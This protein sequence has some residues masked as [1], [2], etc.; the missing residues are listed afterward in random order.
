MKG[1]TFG[2][3]TKQ[4]LRFEWK[5]DNGDPRW[6]ERQFLWNITQEDFST[7]HPW[8]F[9]AIH[10]KARTG[11]FSIAM[12]QLR[13]ERP[14]KTNV[15]CL[16]CPSEVGKRYLGP[17]HCFVLS[18][19]CM[20]WV[21]C[22]ARHQTKGMPD[23]IWG[24]GVKGT[25][26]QRHISMGYIC[27][28]CQMFASSE[29]G[30]ERIR[31][32]PFTFCVSSKRILFLSSRISG[33]YTVA[34][35]FCRP[36]TQHRWILVFFRWMSLQVLLSS[37]KGSWFLRSPFCTTPPPYQTD[38]GSVF[39]KSLENTAGKKVSHS[40]GGTMFCARWQSV[41]MRCNVSNLPRR[42]YTSRQIR[43]ICFGIW[44]NWLKCMGKKL[45]K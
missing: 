5:R 25:C 12:L 27:Q 14:G 21:S 1:K 31:P 9:P 36:C 38:E 2:P 37:C 41:G 3:E 42:K 20:K 30:M 33:V 7:D 19:V 43:C 10:S 28:I 45:Q 13:L 15:W 22:A 18:A 23:F 6:S 24:F 8:I 32:N 39:S 40:N 26:I 34:G 16:N 4:K 17:K 44:M 29:D 35:H 11:H